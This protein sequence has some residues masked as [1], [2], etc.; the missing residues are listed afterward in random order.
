MTPAEKLAQ[1]RQALEVS[2]E[3]AR[4]AS[5]GDW[6]SAD[7]ARVIEFAHPDWL[8]LVAEVPQPRAAHIAANDPASVLARNA[9]LQVVLDGIEA[10]MG[11]HDAWT[12]DP[13]ICNAADHVWSCRCPHR[14]A[15]R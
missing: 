5:L 14:M 12:E 9:A 7:G 2:D 11:E 8:D 6:W 15:C 4:A 10:T 3:T 1:L 13:M